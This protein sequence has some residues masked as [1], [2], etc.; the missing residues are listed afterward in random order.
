MPGRIMHGLRTVG[1]NN[2]VFLLDEVDKLVSHIT[3][4]DC[5]H[6]KI[7]T[8]S[9]YPWWPSC[10]ST[11]S[12]RPRAKQLI[13]RPVSFC[14]IC[15]HWNIIICIVVRIFL[16]SNKFYPCIFVLLCSLID[17]EI[18]S[19]SVAPSIPHVLAAF[20]GNAIFI[21]Y[22]PVVKCSIREIEQICHPVSG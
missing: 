9:W 3:Y 18:R 20:L 14:N 12:V 1:V 16:K 5:H 21:W 17:I 2:P 8:E 22:V 7:V 19:L 13:C 11:G 6:L 4:F 15:F 10:S